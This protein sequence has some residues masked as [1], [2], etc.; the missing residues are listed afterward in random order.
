MI[1]L[2]PT[3]LCKCFPNTPWPNVSPE[4]PGSGF[5][6]APRSFVTQ[7][8]IN[9]AALQMQTNMHNQHH[10]EQRQ[11]GEHQPPTRKHLTSDYSA[12]RS[13]AYNAR[14]SSQLTARITNDLISA[15]A[16]IS[17]IR[18]CTPD[19]ALRNNFGE[20]LLLESSKLWERPPSSVSVPSLLRSFV[21]H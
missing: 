15:V 9:D 12:C 19:P 18:A 4:H 21:A 16:T 10:G 17:N 5:A 14:A 6:P 2:H 11:E 7:G 3:L 20:S 8:L 13:L 1:T